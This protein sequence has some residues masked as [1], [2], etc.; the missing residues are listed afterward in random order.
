LFWCAAT[1]HVYGQ[2]KLLEINEAAIVRVER[3][4]N[5]FTKALG[6]ARREEVLVDFD[7]LIFCQVTLW[8]VLLQIIINH[9]LFSNFNNFN[10]KITIHLTHH[11]ALVPF[12]DLFF[13]EIRVLLQ[14]LEVLFRQF[15][16][17]TL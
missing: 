6:T 17:A 8:T 10:F 2:Q 11:K 16:F 5:M 1:R 14:E 9:L 15:W 12:F 13:S 3:A 4:K 7:E